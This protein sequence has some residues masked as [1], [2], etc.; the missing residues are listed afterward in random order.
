MNQKQ[1]MPLETNRWFI[2]GKFFST[3]STRQNHPDWIVQFLAKWIAS[4]SIHVEGFNKNTE[5]S[6]NKPFL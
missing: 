4:M 6:W 3:P 5:I 1:M 2:I